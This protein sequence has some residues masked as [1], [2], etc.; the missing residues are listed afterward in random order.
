MGWLSCRDGLAVLAPVH[1]VAK[2]D[3]VAWFRLGEEFVPRHSDSSL[4]RIII[5]QAHDLAGAGAVKSLGHVLGVVDGAV[6]IVDG[7][8]VIVDADGKPVE[9]SA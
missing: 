3:R 4:A 9:L 1:H 6:E 2:D 7:A 8:F 5:E